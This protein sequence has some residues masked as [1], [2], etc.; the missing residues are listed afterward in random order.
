MNL[1]KY[2]VKSNFSVLQTTNYPYIFGGIPKKSENS[3]LKP[4]LT[5]IFDPNVIDGFQLGYKAILSSLE[6]KDKELL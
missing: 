2:C 1:M 3:Y 6:Y 5:K 4:F